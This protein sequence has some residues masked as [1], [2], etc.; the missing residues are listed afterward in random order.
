MIVVAVRIAIHH[1]PLLRIPVNRLSHGWRSA[2]RIPRSLH[3]H[4]R[5]SRLR[6]RYELNRRLSRNK[7]WCFSSHGHRSLLW[8]R[9]RLNVGHCLGSS[10]WRSGTKDVGEC[11]ITLVAISHPIAG[12]AAS[13]ILAPLRLIVGHV[14]TGCC[15]LLNRHS[16]RNTANAA[17][18]LTVIV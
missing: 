16:R 9:H 5:C 14:L 18:V 17:L 7:I 10:R 3:C 12:M 15:W 2:T 8:R 4:G 11:S 1:W 13:R 6:R